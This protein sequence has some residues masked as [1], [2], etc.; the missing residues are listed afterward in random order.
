MVESS[1]ATILPYIIGLLVGGFISFISG[2][3]VLTYKQKQAVT[4][5]LLDQYFLMRDGISDLVSTLTTLDLKKELSA[6]TRESLRSS[7]ARL[8]Y[9]HY[10]FLPN[11]VLESLVLLYVSLGDK[12]GRI[13]AISKGL[14]MPIRDYKAIGEFSKS[15]SLF[16]N[17]LVFSGMTIFSKD[18]TIRSNEAI[19]LH[20]RNV[21]LMLNR[22]AKA[23][24]L[25]M[26]SRQF[27]KRDQRHRLQ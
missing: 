8:T 11:Q 5:K 22:Y 18:R 7:L 23:G 27:K 17:A 1:E 13:F 26:L 4:L 15:V 3:V 19:S 2:I 21:L 24:D 25:L 10:D 9:K 16:H 6:E 12:M 20:A 14:V